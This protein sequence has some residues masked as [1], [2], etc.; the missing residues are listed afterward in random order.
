M[1]T[2]DVIYDQRVIESRLREGAL[3]RADL[4]KY[5]KSLPD[6]KKDADWITIE[7]LASRSYL[8]GIRSRGTDSGEGN[9]PK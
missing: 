8:R 1:K 3:T 5:L 6:R 2:D 9:K 7:D 4:E